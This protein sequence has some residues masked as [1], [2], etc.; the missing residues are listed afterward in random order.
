MSEGKGFVSEETISSFNSLARSKNSLLDWELKSTP[1]NFGN[2]ILVSSQ[3]GI[4]SQGFVGEYIEMMGKQVPGDSVCGGKIIDPTAGISFS[5]QDDS[6]SKLSSRD[7]SLIDLKLGRIGDR[8]DV[9]NSKLPR[10]P[11]GLSSSGSSTPPKRIRL[12]GLNSHTAFCQVYGCNKDLSSSKDYHKRHKVCELHSKTAKVIVN[13]IEQRFCQQ[14]SRFHLLAEFDDGKRSCRKRLAGHNERRR[15][16]QVGIHSGRSGRMLQSYND[17]RFQGTTSFICQDILPSGFLQPEKYGMSDWCHRVKVEDRSD[18]RP[19]PA[20]PV[21]NGHLRSKLLF[22]PEVGKEFPSFH[23]SGA[24]AVTASVFSDNSSQYTHELGAAGAG[25]RT[26]LHNT[27]LGC[28]EFNSFSTASTI[29][30]FSGTSDSGC[31]LSLLSSQSQY[32]TNNQ[33]GFSMARALVKPGSHTCYGMS[34]VSEKLVGAS[35]QASTSGVLDK[36]PSLGMN[37]V[38]GGQ[39]GPIMMSRS[40]DAVNFEITDGIFQG[41]DFLNSKDRLACEDVPTIDLLQLSSQLQ[42]VEDQRQSMQM[43]PK[44]DA[45]CCL[46]IT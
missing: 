40:I 26:F 42:R 10:V 18:Y 36:L 2:N 25:S 46:R 13:G 16:P 41:S 37:P 14:C 12:S 5:R 29:Q 7:S 3:Q 8:R 32:S 21:T 15:K 35:S 30:R 43:K 20:V 28:E 31:A 24:N 1:C 23:E 33:S 17:S 27:M 39:V 19:L 22:P 38:D 4:E 44:N 9:H 34:Q 45:F 6:T 11:P